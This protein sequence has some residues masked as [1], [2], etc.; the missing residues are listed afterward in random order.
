MRVLCLLFFNDT[1]T[2]AV[3]AYG[4]P[5]SLHDALPIWQGVQAVSHS[6][7]CPK[8]YRRS[9]LPAKSEIGTVFPGCLSRPAPDRDSIAEIRPWKTKLEM[10]NTSLKLFLR[11]KSGEVQAISMVQL[12]G[13]ALG[14]VAL[15]VPETVAG[16]SRSEELRGGKKGV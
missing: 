15:S 10:L 6:C 5:L 12:E 7:P 3:Y 16:E 9:G 2:T 1:A 14:A 13:L 4:H 11:T 8:G